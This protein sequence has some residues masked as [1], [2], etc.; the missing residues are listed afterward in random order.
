MR[1]LSLVG[2]CILAAGSLG[3]A[4]TAPPTEASQATAPTLRV[5]APL[6]R[7][8]G[9][10]DLH[11]Y[12]VSLSAGQYFEL[13]ADQQG[14]D[15]IVALVGPDD[16]P[17]LQVD[18]QTDVLGT[19]RLYVLAQTTGDHR[20]ELK[21]SN[22]AA[23]R[24][25]YTIALDVVRN[26]APRDT[27]R[28]E[29]SGIFA[30]AEAAAAEGTGDSRRRAIALYKEAQLAWRTGEERSAEAQ[31]LHRMGL[32]LSQLAEYQ[33]ALQRYDEAAS[34]RHEIGDRFKE[35]QSLHNIGSVY[36]YL[37]NYPKSLEYY[38]RALPMRAASGDRNGEAFSLSSIGLVHQSMGDAERGLEYYARAIELWRAVAN[39]AGEALG[40]HNAG[41]AYARLG[42]QQVALRHLEQA[43][44]LRRQLGDRAGEAQTLSQIGSSYAAFGDAS[45][46]L[47]ING[48]ALVLRRQTGDRRGE[49]YT[50]HNIGL[51]HVDLSAP[52]EA[53]PVLNQALAIFHTINDRDGQ[54]LALNGL[55]RAHT[56]LGDFDLAVEHYSQALAL[57][58]ALAS[59]R[60]EASVLHN[61][62]TLYATLG[63]TDKALEH[64]RLALPMLRELRDRS[65]EAQTLV[66]IAR[67]D[68]DRGELTDARL[69]VEAALNIVESLRAGVGTQELRA[70]FRSSKQNAYELYVDV[71]MALERSDAAAGYAG[72]ALRAAERARARGLVEI[73]A[74]A[75][76]DIRPGAD[77]ALADR[78]RSLQRRID[79]KGEWLTR[80]LGGKHREE[81]ATQGEHELDA[82]VG[83][84]REVQLELRARNPRYAAL[85]QPVPVGLR[86]IQERL[87][88]EGT[89]LLE[90]FL[91]ARRSYLWAVTSS[92]MTVHELPPRAEIE[93][94][95]RRMYELVTH[96]RRE[97]RVQARLAATALSRILLAPVAGELRDR[98]LAIVPD[99]ALQYVPFAALPD[100][101]RQGASDRDAPPLIVSHEVVTIPS[102]SVLDM[103]RGDPAARTRPDK[104][105]VVLADPVLKRQDPR[106]R[107]ALLDS[108]RGG[109]AVPA[110]SFGGLATS[111]TDTANTHAD[112]VRAAQ[113]SGVASFAR[114]RF[115]RAEAQAIAATAGP[116][117]S[118][119]AFDFD[120]SR[121]LATSAELGRYRIVHFATHTLINS[122]RPQLSGIVLSLVRPDGEP[123]NGFLRLHDI[124]NLTLGAELVVLSGCQTALGKDVAGE[125]LVGLTRGFMYAGAPRVV[126]SLWDVRDRATAEFMKRFYARMLHRELRPAAAL[127]AAQVSMLSE[128]RWESPLY[129]AG[130]ILQGDWR[131]TP[132]GARTQWSE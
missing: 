94:A 17:L 130:F 108:T 77:A 113:E 132:S 75:Q 29:A 13:S 51:A 64:Y 12:L 62:G 123:Q 61:L 98:R 99:G 103:L 10:P 32:A 121:G 43:L 48:Q 52:A 46:S 116:A 117:S 9:P 41:S 109:S 92:S 93:T 66:G 37:A 47:E 127:R 30:R 25:R 80:L 6:E 59:R 111:R 95:A 3:G 31:T 8:M 114:L 105:V 120:A 89:L 100:V 23:P 115:T 88:D 101:G 58:R 85:T 5:G 83:E 118:L 35:G 67:A 21:P 128:R 68:H 122:E 84:Y 57:Y 90:Y 69:Q 60:L 91:G 82:L 36:Y 63:E 7:E 42:E 124:Y 126:A 20:V 38:E 24:G 79:A 78:A 129:W 72:A 49:A 86:E 74:E 19:E 15:V 26:P 104:T 34:I 87:L 4:E 40:L 55:G 22:V 110:S 76:A 16:R 2:A 70:T 14:V 107:A 131:A 106:V 65:G 119:T 33:E 1:F 44:T 56:A 27:A 54:A 39:R 28:I 50:L 96:P 102:A 97:T 18:V 53:L 125:G 73:L 45:K 81:E 11:T 71:L 112:L